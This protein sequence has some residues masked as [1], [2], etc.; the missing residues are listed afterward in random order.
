MP[1]NKELV[2]K[3][4][5]VWLSKN[6]FIRDFVQLIDHCAG[7]AVINQKLAG[8]SPSNIVADCTP[9]DIIVD[10]PELT[11]HTVPPIR[12]Y[13][14]GGYLTPLIDYSDIESTIFKMAF[15]SNFHSVD[16]WQWS[17]HLCAL[18]AVYAYEVHNSIGGMGGCLTVRQWF[19]SE[20]FK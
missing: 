14:D 9:I 2:R 10:K 19:D 20:V 15:N 7:L 16:N 13:S 18:E 6:G 8:I 5:F 12:L 17:M 1:Q 11:N 3:L 4:L